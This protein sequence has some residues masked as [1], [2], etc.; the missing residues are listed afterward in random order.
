MNKIAEELNKLITLQ[1]TSDMTAVQQAYV[2]GLSD[3]LDIVL[4]YENIESEWF[5][6]SV[7]DNK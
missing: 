4:Q 5:A 7:E 3:A 1:I 6:R 2:A